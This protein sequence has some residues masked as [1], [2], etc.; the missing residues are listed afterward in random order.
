MY[1]SLYTAMA[2]TNI[3]NIENRGVTSGYHSSNI[4]GPQSFFLTETAIYIVE[5]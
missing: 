3:S 4:Y 2:L 5:R 1:K